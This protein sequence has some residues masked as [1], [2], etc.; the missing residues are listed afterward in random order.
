LNNQESIDVRD[1]GD[2]TSDGTNDLMILSSL[3]AS[4]LVRSIYTVDKV[5]GEELWR[6]SVSLTDLA[7]KGAREIRIEHDFTGDGHIDVLAYRQS[8]MPDDL[9]EMGNHSL[10]FVIDGADGSLAW[11]QHVTDQIFYN[12]SLNV[13][14]GL[15]ADWNIVNRRITTIDTTPDLNND[16][17]PDIMVGG[18]GGK[19]YLIDGSDG[20]QIWNR[21]DEDINWLPWYPQVITV[22]DQSRPGL[23]VTDFSFL[24]Y[25]T[26]FST[27]GSISANYTWRYPQNLNSPDN[28][29]VLPGS[30]RLIEDLNNDGYSDVMFF[31]I[32]EQDGD[33]KGAQD[34]YSCHILSGLNGHA[35]GPGFS[36]GVSNP[37][38]N[39][40]APGEDIA[41]DDTPFIYDFNNNGVKDAVIFKAFEGKRAPPQIIA[42]DGQNHQEIWVNDEIFEFAF[43]GGN[44]LRIVDI[45]NDDSTPEIVIGSSRWGIEGADIHI[46]DGENGELINTISYEEQTE[47]TDWNS[48]QPVNSISTVNDLSGD[49]INDIM[50]QRTAIIDGDSII[51]LELVDIQTNKLLRQVP[52]GSAVAKDNGDVNSD[53]KT[54]ILVSQ[55]NSLYCINGVYSLSI[56]SPQNK[57][58]VDNDFSLEWD[59]KGVECEVFVDGISYG[60]YDN[61]KA[62]LKLSGGD[63]DIIVETTDEFGGKLSDTILVKIPISNTPWIINIASLIALIIFIV[64]MLIMKRAKLKIREEHWREKRRQIESSKNAQ[65]KKIKNVGGKRKKDDLSAG[66]SKRAKNVDPKPKEVSK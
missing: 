2:T 8:D 52:V 48:A 56:L 59:L 50:V 39:S 36:L 15:Y 34:T 46:I 30:F 6:Y 60:Y 58:S 41:N 40:F 57:A 5:T 10:V 16:G 37:P 4:S 49:N 43:S 55:E 7:V 9:L 12:S 14:S 45:I 66:K 65:R 17:I 62:E 47:F 3:G 25:F 54:D 64:I 42:I 28:P 24:I 33:E 53:G 22:R 27:N 51:V 31:S 63:H 19:V 21:T 23:I 32:E 29:V 38:Q 1:I 26:N 44:P 20:S 61:G 18:Q 11:E 35:L 13:S